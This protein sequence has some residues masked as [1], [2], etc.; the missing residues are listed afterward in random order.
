MG[1]VFFFELEV[2]I[3][4]VQF[5]NEGLGMNGIRLITNLGLDINPNILIDH[6]GIPNQQQ[7]N[8]RE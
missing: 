7:G 8:Y 3:V 1:G 5:P 6:K 2:N 4:A